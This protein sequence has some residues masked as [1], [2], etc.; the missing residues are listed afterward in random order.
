MNAIPCYAMKFSRYLDAVDFSLMLNNP[1]FAKD[2]AIWY[3]WDTM[4]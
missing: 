1:H 4:A 2:G 3:V